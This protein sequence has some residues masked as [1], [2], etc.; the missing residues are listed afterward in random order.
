[1]DRHTDERDDST[2]TTAAR[3]A[4]N[5]QSQTFGQTI[6]TIFHKY[7]IHLNT[8]PIQKL[9]RQHS[10]HFVADSGCHQK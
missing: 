3:L 2:M 10:S 6:Y 7:F 8:Y 5:S 1:M 4:N 9:N